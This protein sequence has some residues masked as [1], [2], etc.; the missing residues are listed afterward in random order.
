MKIEI[1]E[2][3][4][5]GQKLK[6]EFTD[7]VYQAD[8]S[9]IV[10]MGDTK[11]LAT[12][13][14]SPQ[15]KE[16]IDFLPLSVEFEEKSY[17][18]GRIIGSQFQKRE[19][20][21]TDEAILSSRII[22][23]TIRPLFDKW[24]RNEIQV[25]ATVIS[26]GEYDP[27]FLS[28]IASSLALSVSKIPF[29][30]P[31]SSIRVCRKSGKTIVNPTYKDREE[32]DCQILVCS[33]SFGLNMI[34]MSGN[35]I[36]EKETVE[37]LKEAKVYLDKILDFQKD[38]VSKIGQKKI[39]VEKPK[40]N[41]KMV[42]LFNEKMSSVI[43]DMLF[44][45]ENSF[46]SSGKDGLK[47]V[48]ES[49]QNICKEKLTKEESLNSV[50]F[51]DEKIDDLVHTLALNKNKRFDGRKID[52]IRPLFAK[53]GNVSALLHG[54][55]I[56]YRGGTHILAV[57][58]LGGPKDA[59]IVDGMEQNQIKH[60]ML[61]YNF[62]P[63]SVGEVGRF[64]GLNR[65]VVGHGAL[66][67][68]SILPVLPSF[69]DFPY[70]IR[71]VAESMSS[72]GS[73]SMASVCASTLSL[74]DAGVPIKRPV[75]GISSGLILSEKGDYVILTDIAGPEDHYGDMDFKVS[76]TSLGITAVQ[77]DIKI[78]GVSIDILKE[79]FDRAKEARE[80]ILDVISSEIKNPREKI[81]DFAPTVAKIK[82][83]QDQIGLVI[84]PSGKTINEIKNKTSVSDITIEN[85]GSVYIVGKKESVSMAKSIIESMTKKFEKGDR[86]SVKIEKIAPF[87][88]F[89]SM[90]D[91]VDGLIHISEIKEGFSSTVDKLLK[92]GDIVPVIIKDVDEKG[93][94]KLSIKEADP[95]F[96][97][98]K[99]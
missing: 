23:R 35:E 58:T 41:T 91:R 37:M 11:V 3:D 78:M 36:S 76:G 61:H 56:F 45:S 60:F 6:V 31:A 83:A 27:D 33:S 88:A 1:F 53:A 39:L 67:E 46:I 10:S 63:Y 94:Y 20:R 17:A 22:D 77:M 85:D 80:K 66:A 18:S 57:T 34:E 7:L 73:T 50:M 16:G 96:F 87:G 19:G 24:I 71:V 15:V 79:A 29:N 65:R 54:S 13:V 38:I 72:N 74:M 69:D 86:L 81:S 89:A 40:Y 92:V 8:G 30:S 43:E 28:V 99:K 70:T 52:E 21:P 64:G 2:L 98:N 51:I 12:T 47:K 84:G 14:I 75:A 49:W 26:L 68:K 97:N 9:V 93:R 90:S 95:N 44:T 32:S 55:G 82:I 4:L 5:F 62:P 25:T 59:L 48:F 42:E